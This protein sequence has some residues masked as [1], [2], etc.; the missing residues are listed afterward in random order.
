[1]SSEWKSSTVGQIPQHWKTIEIGE[2]II[3][4]G[5][6]VGVMYPGKHTPNGVPLIKAGDVRNGKINRD[7]TFLVSE[8][9][10]TTYKRTQ[11]EGGELLIVLVGNPGLSAVVH[12][13]LKGWN[14]ARALAVLKL[15]NPDDGLFISY[16][17]QSR[18]VKHILYSFCN[19]T[20][21]ATLNLKELKKLPIPWPL[22]TERK[23]I[24]HIL[25]TL[26]DKI[27]L[28]RK[29]NQTLE[30]MAQALFQ[31][32]FVDFDPVLDNALAAGN[33][34]PEPFQKKAAKRN[35]A[36]ASTKLINT[37]PALA[38]LFPSTFVFN[39]TLS[40]WIPEGWKVKA[41]KELTNIS[42]SKRIFAKEYVT[43]GIP[44]YRGK[45]ISKLSEGNSFEPEIY[46]TEDRFDELETKYGVPKEDDILL[47]SVGTIGNS[48]LVGKNDKFYFKDGNLTCFSDY[49]GQIKGKYLKVWLDSKEAEREIENIKIGSTQQAITISSLNEINLIVANDLIL[50]EFN[51]QIESLF[52]EKKSRVDQITTLIKTRDT[53]LPKLI[54]G[55]I[56][57]NGTN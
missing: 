30:S 46:I 12:D 50:I 36:E 44:F 5:I 25:G 13:D 22:E 37:N 53:L 6:S 19:T 32:W 42:S 47:T 24:K 20:V 41:L 54:S 9:V 38:K 18:V 15:K 7:I 23:S 11:L 35:Q 14:A 55:K 49:K 26:D 29:M 51:L 56:K 40:K 48:Y 27:E 43:S 52:N 21:Q 3:E 33:P 39:E 31:S 17:L 1:M 8:E 10:N 45:E 16:C 4:K 28:N 2:L 34:I 57:T